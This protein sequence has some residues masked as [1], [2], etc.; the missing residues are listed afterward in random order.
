M[1][2]DLIAE[3]YL[4]TYAEPV[5]SRVARLSD[6]YDAAV[7]VP[8]YA[9]DVSTFT[10]LSD[11]AGSGGKNLLILVVNAPLD[12]PPHYVRTND[13]FLKAV[14]ES[15]DVT[16]LGAGIEWVA[17]SRN[18]SSQDVLLMD[19]TREP[20]RLR[21]KEGV[22]RARKMGLDVTLSL[23]L[24]GQVLSPMCGSTDADVTLPLG[25]FAALSSAAGEAPRASLPRTSGIIF[26]YRHLLPEEGPWE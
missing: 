15:G 18:H 19:A 6:V 3:K 9:E 11:A 12:A 23:Y 20:L 14:R 8:V 13:A 10:R 7:V 5:A 25:Y 22:G 4:K 2:H 24:K 26:P 21:A 16:A 17:R 1:V